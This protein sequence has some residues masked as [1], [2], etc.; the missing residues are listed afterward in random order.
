[1]KSLTDIIKQQHANRTI[2]DDSMI[3]SLMA[4]VITLAEDNCVL[5]D[6]LDTCQRLAA[7]HEPADDKAIDAYVPND[8]LVTARIK[9]HGEFF[10]TLFSRL[11]QEPVT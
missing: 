6:R 8:E 1:M 10:A 4:E 5:R 11:N 2:S 3:E 9:A 7:Q